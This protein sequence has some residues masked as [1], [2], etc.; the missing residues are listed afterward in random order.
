MSIHALWS[1]SFSVEP[2]V[3]RPMLAGMTLAQMADAMRDVLP[4]VFDEIGIVTVDGVTVPR[5]QWRFVR[6][7]VHGTDRPV[8]VRFHVPVHGGDDGGG[9]AIL[10]TLAAIAL[11]VATGG[12][13]AGALQGTR[14][15]QL[16]GVSFAAN[17]VSAYV[18]AGVVSVIGSNLIS[19]IAGAPTTNGAGTDPAAAQRVASASG[20]VL[21]FGASVPR[22]YGERRIYPPFVAQP[23][24]TIDGQDEIVEVVMALA[25]PHR[26]SDVQI[27]ASPVSSMSNVEIETHEGWPGNPNLR[28]VRRFG[29][30]SAPNTELKGHVVDASD[31]K[32]L[33]PSIDV[34]LAVPQPAI[35]TANRING[36]APD[37]FHMHVVFPQGVGRASLT[38]SEIRIPFRLRI[39]PSGGEWVNLPEL[40]FRGSDPRP[41]KSS[42]VFRWASDDVPLDMSRVEGWVEAR[43]SAP[44]QTITPV[45]DGWQSDDY[46]WA[47]SGDEYVNSN[48]LNTTGMR[49]L[50][51]AGTDLFVTLD[52]DTFEPGR[53]DVEIVRGCAVDET[54]WSTTAYT[55]SG[56]VLDLFAYSGTIPVAPY[57]RDGVSD[58]VSVARHVTVVNRSPINTGNVA[59]LAARA[60]NVQLEQVSVLAGGYVK[61]W[62]GT[63]WQNWTV[64]SNPAPHL[65]DTMVSA[66]KMQVYD[67]T[68]IDD[69]DLVAWRTH[70]IDNGYSINAVLIGT[71][72]DEAARI[73]AGCGYAQM[74]LSEKM[75]VVYDRDRSADAPVQMITPR[76]SRD[77]KVN[78]PYRRLPDGLR[79]RFDDE[80]NDYTERTILVLR[81][82]IE[83]DVGRYEE[84]RF[85][86]ITSEAAAIARARYE[87][88]VYE[89]R[90]ATYG[91]DMPFEALAIR[92]GSLVSHVSDDL[93]DHHGYGIV[94]AGGT[95]S[96]VIDTA[97]T[98]LNN[99][100]P[101]DVSVPFRTVG[102][103]RDLGKRSAAQIRRPNGDVDTVLL[104][105]SVGATNTLTFDE[106]V[107]RVP[108]GALITVG[109][110]ATVSKRLV[111]TGMKWRDDDTA[112]IVAVPEA[113]EIWT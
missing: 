24:V 37:E 15:A 108:E 8:Q 72:F 47:G 22:V 49:H 109:P 50:S 6:P 48:N 70:C 96:V 86:G 35:Y 98:L 111:V 113:P 29:Q 67:D 63:A 90:A 17:S 60:R 46:F 92:R 45:T 87:L 100:A 56:S 99:D 97:V 4:P 36:I 11:T 41:T 93:S 58:M 105:G 66:L 88:R 13:A 104:D 28:L 71:G 73:I 26:L 57:S 40:Y 39:R 51:A 27:G 103:I 81:D 1:E 85:E 30:T 62:D 79:V 2:P 19:G 44:G 89:K 112:S 107:D 16:L 102:R 74:R 77:F 34:T 106:S 69:E 110:H 75:G 32:R 20:N 53:Y 14:L 59:I 82:G 21:Q 64:S 76:N 68:M 23:L 83:R 101:R 91:W 31:Q 94:T 54:A 78:L 42:I 95:D 3:V 5:E 18:A 43:R 52:P 10:A 61:D 84:V 65:R 12:I 55:V 25:G 7:K 33:D 38:S 9:K 80:D